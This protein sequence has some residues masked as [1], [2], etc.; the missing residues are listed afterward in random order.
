MSLNIIPSTSEQRKQLFAETLL[1]KTDKI[2][3]ISDN[4]VVNGVAY[5]IAKVAG[6][7][8]KDIIQAISKLYPDTAFGSQLD[9]IAQDYG[10]SSRFSASQSSTYVRI[11]GDVGTQYI[12]GTHVF[13]STDGIQFDLEE[14]ITLGVNQF[15]YA[16]VRSVDSGLKT[17]VKPGTVNKITP[18]PIG[19]R[20]CVNEYRATG[21]RD[22]EDDTLF[23]QRIKEGP[24]IL[25]TGTLAVIEQ[26]FMTI[27]TNVL[28][29]IYQ[30]INSRGQLKIAIVTQNGIDLNASELNTLLIRGERFFGLSELRP[31]GRQSYGIELVNI[32]WQTFDLSFRC[33]L[34]LSAIPDDVR[35]DIQT[36]ISKYLD[37]RYFKSGVDK[38]EW[39][40]LLQIVK[41]TRGIKYVPDEYFYPRVDIAVDKNK[42]PRLRGFLMLNL[43]GGVINTITGTL[44][45]VYYPQVADFSFIST[46]LRTI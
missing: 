38:I 31:F 7:A 23:R 45:P 33:D 40:N 29:C 3:K 34:L 44:N 26:A 13:T 1:N 37:F 35:I 6:K 42:L 27:N 21:G 16:K 5:G 18:T 11:V 46:V 15:S 2:N 17:N 12:A 22:V 43:Q 20:F 14:S 36:R 24:N 28:R 30:G 4:S 8:E 9:Q 10:I 39:D 32:E 25:A 19:H 41:N